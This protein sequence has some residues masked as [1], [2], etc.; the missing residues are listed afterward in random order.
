MRHFGSHNINKL[1]DNTSKIYT[2]IPTA[3]F[4]VALKLKYEEEENKFKYL[5]SL[6]NN[7]LEYEQIT[8][9]MD[10]IISY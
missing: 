1:F 6:K 2:L 8:I 9:E 7:N 5:Q 3:C 10:Q 4:N